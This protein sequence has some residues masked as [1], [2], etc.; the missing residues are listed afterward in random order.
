MDQ[1]HTNPRAVK[2][3]PRNKSMVVQPELP[4]H[5]SGGLP[6]QF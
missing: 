6:V 3:S 2:P 1:A 4:K 5:S